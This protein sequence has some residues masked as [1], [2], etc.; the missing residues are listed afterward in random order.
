[1]GQLP[2]DAISLIET[3]EDAEA[4]MPRDPA[5]LA[6]VTQTTL[7]VDDTAEI[8][9]ILKRR[10]PAIVTPRKDDICYATSNRQDAVKAIAG[11]CE[12][13]IVLGAPN[14]SNAC[15]LVE[16]A[17]RAGAPRSVL[18]QRSHDLDLSIFDGMTRV[19]ITAGAS[20]PESLVQDVLGL[21]R[22]VR[23]LEIEEIGSVE[24]TVHFKL[25]RMLDA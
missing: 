16:V 23:S 19:G 12:L 10:F 21:L 18:I 15:R 6:Y 22:K 7:S 11:H 17:T 5:R 2:K 8:V 9:A 13:V 20:A 14:S 4:F 3:M 1:M 24:E 25:P